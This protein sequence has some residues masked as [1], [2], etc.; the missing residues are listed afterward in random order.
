MTL[1]NVLLVMFLTW[2]QLILISES[3]RKTLPIIQLHRPWW[4]ADKITKAGQNLL[5]LVALDQWLYLL[6]LDLNLFFDFSLHLLWISDSLRPLQLYCLLPNL[7]LHL[8]KPSNLIPLE[9]LLLPLLPLSPVSFSLP[10]PLLLYPLHL[11]VV[12]FCSQTSLL[13]LS[14][15]E[16]LLKLVLNASWKD[17]WQV[18]SAYL[19]K[20][21]FELEAKL[22]KVVDQL[23]T[24]EGHEHDVCKGYVA[25]RIHFQVIVVKKGR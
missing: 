14:I 18:S 11:L 2:N 24:C 5:V 13:K 1:V 3:S 10:A 16:V 22:E 7:I 6:H 9:L 19:E 4:P 17:G 8:I 12:P 25:V 20:D 15:N 21:K 23:V